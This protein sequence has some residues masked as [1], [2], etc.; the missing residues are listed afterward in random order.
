MTSTLKSCL[1]IVAFSCC[2]G[3][4]QTSNPLVS[5]EK[6]IYHYLMGTVISA[7]E[8]MPEKDY[9]FKP[10]STVRTFGQLVAHEADAQYEFCSA[11]GGEKNPSPDVEKNKTSKADLIQAVKDAEGYCDK[12][13]AGLTDATASEMVPFVGHQFSKLAVLSFNNAHT[14]EHYGNMV[15]YLRMKKLVPPSSKQQN[16]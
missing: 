15:T 13:Y 3:A 16:Q 1:V 7:A 2:A 11:A 5:S 6:G 9:S 12:V 14:D 8:E 10:V 4:Q